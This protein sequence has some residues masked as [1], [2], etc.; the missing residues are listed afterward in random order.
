MEHLTSGDATLA[1]DPS[2]GARLTSL[3]IAGLELLVPPTANTFHWGCYPMAPWAGRIR[4]G[5]FEFDGRD[6]Q[7]PL[8]MPPHAIHGT[9]Y[10]RPWRRYNGAASFDIDLGPDWPFPGRAVQHF[11]LGPN[12]LDLTMEIH[13]DSEPFPASAGWHPWFQRQLGRGEPA[14]LSIQADSMYARDEHHMATDRLIPPPPGPWDDCFVG[15]RQPVE[16]LWPGALRL[17]MEADVQHWVVYN[18]PEHAF[19]VEPQSA[20]P[21]ALNIEPRLV[22]PEA[23][24]TLNASLHW[25]I[26]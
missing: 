25:E 7:L 6:Y 26:L 12:R 11:R 18:E 23:P 16:I 20:P 5:R 14:Q 19:C 22:T 15:V 2:H 4:Y 9:T 13:S 1:I 8:T 24:L 10:N 21:D 17:C 3:S